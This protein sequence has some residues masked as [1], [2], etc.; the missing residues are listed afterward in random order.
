[1]EL[2]SF[3]G[4]SSEVR[5]STCAREGRSVRSLATLGMWMSVFAHLKKKFRAKR[6]NY[7]T[8][9]DGQPR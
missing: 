1:V 5:E 3:L 8:M 9:Y 7:M 2:I 6:R 4:K